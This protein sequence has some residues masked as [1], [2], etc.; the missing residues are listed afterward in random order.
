MKRINDIKKNFKKVEGTHNRSI[1]ELMSDEFISKNTN[2][3][4]F[5]EMVEKSKFKEEYGTLE[6]LFKSDEWNKYV[7]DNTTFDSWDKMVDEV[8]ASHILKKIGF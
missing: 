6:E 2:F 1:N 4:N 8:S 5:D 3:S 7:C